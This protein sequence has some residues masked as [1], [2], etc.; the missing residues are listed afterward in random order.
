MKELLKSKSMI[1][2]A[3]LVLGVSFISSTQNVVF[4]E[5]ADMTEEVEYLN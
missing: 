5:S 4:E 1:A 3:A 2:V